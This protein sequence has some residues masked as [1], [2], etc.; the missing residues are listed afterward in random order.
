[1][2]LEFHRQVASDILR[3]MRHY[4]EIAG[5]RLAED[6][7]TE[8]RRCFQKAVEAPRTYVVREHDLRRVNLARFP[9]HF[10]FRVVGEQVR[11]LVVRHHRREPSTGSHR[12]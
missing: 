11:V 10:L 9:Y 4:E 3:I 2:G 1:M 8:L 6:F 7:H 5:P 12:R